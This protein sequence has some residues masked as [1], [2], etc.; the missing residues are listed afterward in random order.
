LPGA[1]FEVALSTLPPRLAG[2]AL[3]PLVQPRVFAW[4]DLLARLL[5]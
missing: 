3:L 2:V 4:M 5:R 1:P